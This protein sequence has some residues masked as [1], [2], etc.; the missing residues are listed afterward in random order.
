MRKQIGLIDITCGTLPVVMFF[1]RMLTFPK[2][3]IF[4][5]NDEDLSRFAA[6]TITNLKS[7]RDNTL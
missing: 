7:Q 1:L 5:P 4:F 3:T 2:N 6:T